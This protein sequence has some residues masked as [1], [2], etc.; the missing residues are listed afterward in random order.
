MKDM[1]A[2]TGGGA[3]SSVAAH[4]SGLFAVSGSGFE[5]RIAVETDTVIGAAHRG[6][7]VQ[8]KEPCEPNSG[9]PSKRKSIVDG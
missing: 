5:S 9:A 4:L 2:V 3:T 7:C 8:R 1:S 6:Y